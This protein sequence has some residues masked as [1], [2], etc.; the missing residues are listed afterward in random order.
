VL[1][2]LALERLVSAPWPGNVRE[3]RNAVEH[4]L[5][6]ARGGPIRVEHLPPG[7]ADAAP[8]ARDSLEPLA[9]LVGEIVERAA[10][11]P[12]LEE[13]LVRAVERAAIVKA[14][15]LTAG[16]QVAAAKLL[17]MN[18]TTFRKRMDENGL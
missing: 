9:R 3:L 6:L 13:D 15:E 18:R 10:G 17:D 16:N 2:P 1:D 12:A 8:P 11:R 4:A 7:L 14:L 5:A